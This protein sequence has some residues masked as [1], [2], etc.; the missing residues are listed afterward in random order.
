M[1]LWYFKCPVK[2]EKSVSFEFYSKRLM[3]MNIHDENIQFTK[4]TSLLQ[5][6]RYLS[7]IYNTRIDSEKN[8][9]S[10][11]IKICLSYI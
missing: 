11:L 5:F 6:R 7:R 3:N 1:L 4:A 10:Q 9:K 8:V 2:C